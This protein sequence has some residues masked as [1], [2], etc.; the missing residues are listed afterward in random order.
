MEEIENACL[1]CGC[2]DVC[3][4]CGCTPCEWITQGKDSM[5]GGQEMYSEE[6]CIE[7]NKTCKAMYRLFTYLEYGHLV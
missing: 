4:Q 2:K 5:K 6:Y 7:N 3:L 1:R